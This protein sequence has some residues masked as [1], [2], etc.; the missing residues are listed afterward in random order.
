MRQG[1]ITCAERQRASAPA[2]HGSLRLGMASSVVCGETQGMAI[3]DSLTSSISS[4]RKTDTCGAVSLQ[5]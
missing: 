3:V 2:R 1:W 4:T 5:N